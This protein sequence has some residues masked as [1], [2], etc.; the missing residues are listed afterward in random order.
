MAKK[1]KEQAPPPSGRELEITKAEQEFKRE[2]AVTQA[3]PVVRNVLFILWTA[4]D[5]V[6]VLV[7]VLTIGIYLVNGSF[8]DR[9]SVAQIGENVDT[10]RAVSQA[11]SAVNLV[12]DDAA[13]FLVDDTSYD[14]FATVENPNEDWY[15]TYTYYFDSSQ[16]ST[17]H[18]SGFALPQ[19]SRPVAL[20]SQEYSSR[21]GGV[22]LIVEDVVWRRVDHHNIDDLSAW[23][24]EHDDF[25][26]SDAVYDQS[27]VVIDGDPIARSTFTVRNASP[28]GYWS[29][30]FFVILERAGSVVAV[31]ATTISGFAP[32]DSR[33]IDVNWFGTVPS[34]ANVQVLHNVNFFDEDVYMEE[35]GG[36]T[37][38][39]RDTFDQ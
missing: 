30:E 32:G 20:F 25:E 21:P 38:D 7:F 15:A 26:V 6:L 11:N 2:L 28:Y 34:S 4:V 13:V 22:E 31:N 5:V 3:K 10:T 16:G 9:R 24:D 12:V 35:Q 23:L 36:T 8:A 14:F 39:I 1:K 37:G 33:T 17:D 19:D 27:E 29:P 18:R